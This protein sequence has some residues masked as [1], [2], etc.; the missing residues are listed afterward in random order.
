[1][2]A[3]PWAEEARDEAEG[4][5]IAVTEP[6][7][8]VDQLN[9]YFQRSSPSQ[10]LFDLRY[11]GRVIFA[12]DRDR[13]YQM[14]FDI[15]GLSRR[16]DRT[17]GGD[18]PNPNELPKSVIDGLFVEWWK[19]CLK[20]GQPEHDGRVPK[21]FKDW[22]NIWDA[23]F[24]NCLPDRITFDTVIGQLIAK[25]ASRYITQQ[26]NK[27]SEIVTWEPS[28]GTGGL[29]TRHSPEGISRDVLPF[30]GTPKPGHLIWR[31]AAGVPAPFMDSVR[32]Q[33]TFIKSTLRQCEKA[34]VLLAW[35]IA[36]HI[37]IMIMR[38]YVFPE[39]LISSQTLLDGNQVEAAV[40]EILGDEWF[41][42][43]FEEGEYL[44]GWSVDE[45]LKPNELFAMQDGEMVILSPSGAMRKAEE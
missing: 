33:H 45:I 36:R 3:I 2:L 32:S 43:P 38:R 44:R 4:N 8:I 15:P 5:A 12:I 20:L 34:T 31:P 1:M 28:M 21:S 29:E 7:A 23:T 39:I 6:D 13:A 37:V 9:Q 35:R 42:L 40:K 30:L 14:L 27:A 18:E 16:S 22:P 17:V 19:Q 11:Q 24:V 10:I 41:D 25:E 26:N